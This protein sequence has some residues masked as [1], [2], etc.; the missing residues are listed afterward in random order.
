MSGFK[1]PFCGQ[2]MSENNSTL[3]T[4]KIGF[5][6]I[7]YP[8]FNNPKII[9]DTPLLVVRV[10]KCPNDE[11][12]KETI[13]AH[14]VNGYIE[15]KTVHIY[16]EST[17]IKFPEFIPPAIRNDYE[18]ACSILDKSPKASATLARRCLQGMIHDFWGITEKNLNAEITAL[19]EKV[20]ASQWNAIDGLRKIGNIG[21]HMEKNVECIIDVDPDEARKL[22]RLIELLITQWYIARHDEEQL[23]KDI[24]DM[25]AEKEADRHSVPGGK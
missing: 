12:E 22:L 23:F 19:R 2:Y 14:G 11:C 4:Y 3:A 7:E 1:C 24:N 16:P 10:Y 8:G 18:E 20:S 13:I 6:I 15:D 21:A 17:A 25:A 5:R 9:E